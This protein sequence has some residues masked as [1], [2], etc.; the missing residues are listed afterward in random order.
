MGAIDLGNIGGISPL[1]TSKDFVI[2][3]NYLAGFQCGINNGVET[4]KNEAVY[5]GTPVLKLKTNKYQVMPLS[6]DGKAFGAKP[7]DS[8]YVGVVKNTRYFKDGVVAVMDMGS[9]ELAAL[10]I[11]YTAEMLTE[12]KSNLNIAFR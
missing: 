12:M 6:A 1:D 2:I 7:A 3:P 11:P 4:Y 5:A 9:V 8:V 10:H